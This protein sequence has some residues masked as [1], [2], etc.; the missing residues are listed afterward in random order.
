[1]PDCAAVRGSSEPELM[2]VPIRRSNLMLALYWTGRQSEALAVFRD[3]RTTLAAELGI[4]PGSRLRAACRRPPPGRRHAARGHGRRRCGALTP[5][6]LRCGCCAPH[7]GSELRRC[8]ADMPETP[9]IGSPR[10]GS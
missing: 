6:Q 9:S 8:I 10:L 4:T 3:A 2:L 5:R 1:M 7:R